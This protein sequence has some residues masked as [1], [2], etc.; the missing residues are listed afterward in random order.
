MAVFAEG[1][2]DD[3]AAQN[4]I[5][6]T[7]ARNTTT[8]CFTI[9][10]VLLFSFRD[11]GWLS[12]LPQRDLLFASATSGPP[13][14][15]TQTVWWSGLL[16]VSD[17]GTVGEKELI[18]LKNAISSAQTL[19]GTEYPSASVRSSRERLFHTGFQRTARTKEVRQKSACLRGARCRKS[20]LATEPL[21]FR[22]IAGKRGRSAECKM[23]RS[24]RRLQPARLSCTPTRKSSTM[25][26]SGFS[27]SASRHCGTSCVHGYPVGRMCR[28]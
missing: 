5:I 17:G 20:L 3:G 8:D 7:A 12:V 28:R 14:F 10:R 15:Q 16:I 2:A 11:G 19:R 25:S 13:D 4:E 24:T 21:N 26:F 27:L 18:V 9:I 23:E 22:R 6:T 1:P